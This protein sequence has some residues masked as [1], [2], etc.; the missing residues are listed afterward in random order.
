LV[1]LYVAYGTLL[2]AHNRYSDLPVAAVSYLNDHHC[3][4]NLFNDYNYGG[5]LI[6]KLPSQPDFIDGRMSTWQPQ[7][8]Q[9]FN[10]ID[11][12]NKYYPSVF[13]KYDIRC[14]LLQTSTSKLVNALEKNNWN[15][16]IRTNN[17]I[18][19]EKY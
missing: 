19:L 8:E 3:E 14:A 7:M 2:V 15:Q 6:W 1:T 10:I 9:Y 18:L 13:A 4:G 11:H 12:P 16:I 17:S 5:Y